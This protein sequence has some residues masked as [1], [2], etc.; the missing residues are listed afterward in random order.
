VALLPRAGHLS[1]VE[2]GSVVF[3]G[4][5]SCP[6]AEEPAAAQTDAAALAIAFLEFKLRGQVSAQPLALSWAQSQPEERVVL[7]IKHLFL[8][9][10]DHT[11]L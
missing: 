1:F 5:K 6:A 3:G 4:V 7:G 8:P 9:M 11:D 10:S 2:P